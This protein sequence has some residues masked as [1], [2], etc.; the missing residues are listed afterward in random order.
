MFLAV[1]FSREL[2]DP[3]GAD[4]PLQLTLPRPDSRLRKLNPV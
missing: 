3:R 1:G 2:L 4:L